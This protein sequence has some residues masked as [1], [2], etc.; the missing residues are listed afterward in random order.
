M[1]SR[2]IKCGELRQKGLILFM[3]AKWF[4]FCYRFFSISVYENK[5]NIRFEPP[6]IFPRFR[7]RFSCKKKP[8]VS[9]METVETEQTDFIRKISNFSFEKMC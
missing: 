1:T 7:L 3:S 4:W 9:K 5:K 6:Q 8:F 2:F